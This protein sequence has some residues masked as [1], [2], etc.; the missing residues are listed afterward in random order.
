MAKVAVSSVKPGEYVRLS[1]GENS[2]VWVR[3]AYDKATK[4]YCLEA[5]DDVGRCTF[6][7]GSALV[8]VG[9]TF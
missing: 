5:F 1:A 4:S 7:K 6:R 3:G 2:P 9:F 8:F